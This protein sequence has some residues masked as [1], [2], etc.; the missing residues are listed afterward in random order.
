MLTK[1][2]AIYFIIDTAP[3]YETKIE[4]RRLSTYI[5]RRTFGVFIAFFFTR[6]SH[7]HIFG[8][9]FFSCL[10]LSL[11]FGQSQIN[12][13][14]FPFAHTNRTI[15]RTMTT[16][17]YNAHYPVSLFV[18]FVWVLL[19]DFY[20]PKAIYTYIS[21]S[22]FLIQCQS[23]KI[24]TQKLIPFF[25]TIPFNFYTFSFFI[26]S[27]TSIFYARQQF[28]QFKID[29]VRHS[30]KRKEKFSL[31]MRKFFGAVFATCYSHLGRF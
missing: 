14:L 17:A 11:P 4:V 2:H 13:K 30:R 24:H 16:C 12:E 18:Q 29:G 25:S 27:N 20:I 10:E 7:S 19:F 9:S 28:K 21:L 5:L 3:L 31:E 23:E 8:I 15:F 26:Y 6:I 22:G 1:V